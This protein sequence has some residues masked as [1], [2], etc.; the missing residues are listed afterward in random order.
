M[1]TRT[2]MV[3]LLC[4]LGER[5]QIIDFDM[6][7][8]K[9]SKERY[10]TERIAIDTVV[11]YVSEEIGYEPIDY[12]RYSDVIIAQ[13]TLKRKEETERRLKKA[14]ENKSHAEAELDRLVETFK[15][16]ARI[17]LMSTS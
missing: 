7:T 3:T 8:H 4:R 16:G 9:I 11:Q 14:V 2:E 5:A 1:N 12:V 17:Q 6:K 15:A 10:M 13:E